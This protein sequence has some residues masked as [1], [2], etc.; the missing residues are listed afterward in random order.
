MNIKSIER[1][2]EY[3][4]VFTSKKDVLSILKLVENECNRIDS[5]FL[6]PACGNGNFLIE[7]LNI[8][9]NLTL[10][11]FGK[12]QFDYERN[13]ILS[14]STLYGIDILEDN[15]FECRNFLLE[16]IKEKYFRKFKNKCK[17]D[18]INSAKFILEKNIIWGDALTY[19]TPNITSSPIIFTEWSFVNSTMIQQREFIL[20]QLFYNEEKYKINSSQENFIPMPN[21][22]L[23]LIHFLNLGKND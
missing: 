21:K 19:R 12:N 8:K 23:N 6:E 2:Q 13:S 16:L 9:L 14:L 17:V 10:K 7:I 5:R 4:E 15:V 18:Y 1:V 11:I 3:G 20:S 22:I